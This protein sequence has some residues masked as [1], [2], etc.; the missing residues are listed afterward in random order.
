MGPWGLSFAREGL[1]R[2]RG[3]VFAVLKDQKLP[4]QLQLSAAWMLTIFRP[5]SDPHTAVSTARKL[6]VLRSRRIVRRRTEQKDLLRQA[7]SAVENHNGKSEWGIPPGLVYTRS[8]SRFMI[9][10]A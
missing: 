5:F 6:G 2:Q 4:A 7:P 10:V 8:N 3:L 1:A 9:R